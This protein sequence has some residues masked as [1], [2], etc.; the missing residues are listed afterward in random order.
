M[1][2]SSTS[3]ASRAAAAPADASPD[4]SRVRAALR[5]FALGDPA[6]RQTFAAPSPDALPALLADFRDPARVRSDFPVWAA[7]D[8]STGGFACLPVSEL[9][10]R[11]L[12][13]AG[14]PEERMDNPRHRW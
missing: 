9:L 13:A 12:D 10:G 3:D 5:R 4:P 8:G 11:A 2:S 14:R 6:A 1:P 7:I